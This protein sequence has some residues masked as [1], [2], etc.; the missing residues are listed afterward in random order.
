M[1]WAVLR[2]RMQ[3]Q[4]QGVSLVLV[5]GEDEDYDEL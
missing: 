2:K 4:A 1:V 5:Y 3:D